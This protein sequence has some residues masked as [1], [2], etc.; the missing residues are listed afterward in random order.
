MGTKTIRF[1]RIVL[2]VVCITVS[3]S[4]LFAQPS[5]PVLGPELPAEPI[6]GLPFAFRMFVDEYS[7]SYRTGEI[8]PA[9]AQVPASIQQAAL[10]QPER[11]LRQ[12]AMFLHD[13]GGSAGPSRDDYHLVKR[14]HDWITDNVAYDN[15][16]L[17]GRPGHDGSRY[18]ET[19][20]KYAS[21]PRTTCGGFSRLF[22]AIASEAGLEARKIDGLTR[23]YATYSGVTGDHAWNAVRIND[24]WYI[25]DTTADGRMS[26][27]GSVRSDKRGY[28]DYWL[29]VAPEALLVK[30]WPEQPDEQFIDRPID[31]QTFE[32]MAQFNVRFLQSGLRPAAD[33]PMNDGGLFAGRQRIRLPRDGGNLFSWADL[34]DSV[35]GR[36]S[37]Q[38]LVPRDSFVYARLYTGGTAALIDASPVAVDYDAS[39]DLVG[40]DEETRVDNRALVEYRPYDED[41]RLATIT[42]SLPSESAGQDIFRARYGVRPLDFSRYGNTVYS[43]YLRASRTDGGLLPPE[44]MLVPQIAAD[45]FGVNIGEPILLD[46]GAFAIDFAHPPGVD[47]GMSVRDLAGESIPG[48]H[49]SAFPQPGV[50]RYVITPPEPGQYIAR[51][52]AKF[53]T[54]ELYNHRIAYYRFTS[55]KEGLRHMPTGLVDQQPIFHELGLRLE[56]V[57]F[58]G[59]AGRYELVI[60]APPSVTLTA[61]ITA[62]DHDGRYLR[63]SDGSPVRPYMHESYD[64]TRR[65]GRSVYR[66]FFSPGLTATEHDG[67]ASAAERSEF[68]G[69]IA[70]V[71]RLHNGEYTTVASVYL[72]PVDRETGTGAGPFVPPFG[73]IARQNAF[74]DYGLSVRYDNLETA[75]SDGRVALV[76]DHPADVEISSTINATDKSSRDSAGEYRTTGNREYSYGATTRVIF[77]RPPDAEPYLFRVFAKRV[78]EASSSTVIELLLDGAGFDPAARASAIPPVWQPLLGSAFATDGFE[79]EGVE[80]D[81]RELVVTVTGPPDVEMRCLLRDAANEN[82][83][84]AYRTDS[85]LTAGRM[86]HTFTFTFPRHAAGERYQVRI[87]RY[88]EG[89]YGLRMRMFVE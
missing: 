23:T 38:L 72:P 46:D 26:Q 77:V 67:Y 63:D 75:A 48:H 64:A 1:S 30:N 14:I 29:L 60:E 59:D 55:T 79:L 83:R 37:V 54:D 45:Y 85:V 57:D 22:V 28:S 56:G 50:K 68:A 42:W 88:D 17:E 66:F 12:L 69:F 73:S 44:N 82:V 34:Y 58:D 6:P 21:G 71:F 53:A 41:Y 27:D 81:G 80:L 25:V 13:D 16:L 32:S 76:I 33:E 52:S 11:G 31:F 62:I 3:S 2:V 47:V 87:Y 39:G 4:G 7:A 20:L 5:L 24:R 43:F 51:F 89:T 8:D 40:V 78:G 19:F 70:S 61:N 65:E 36:Y 15:Y 35:D 86:R 74:H 9:I 49:F 18:P 10:T 84:G